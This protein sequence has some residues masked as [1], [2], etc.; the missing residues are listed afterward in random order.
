MTS[1]ICSSIV[2]TS[3]TPLFLISWTLQL[4]CIILQRLHSCIVH[5]VWYIMLIHHLSVSCQ[6]NMVENLPTL[7]GQNLA[8]TL[9]C[10]QTFP[11]L[12]PNMLLFVVIKEWRYRESVLLVNNCQSPQTQWGFPG[13]GENQ[14]DPSI[15]IRRSWVLYKTMKCSTFWK[16]LDIGNVTRPF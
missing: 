15:K 6:G 12:I 4:Q 8:D 16:C 2:N 9:I 3:V 14:L 7:Y 1:R 10:I 13:C 5:I 11:P